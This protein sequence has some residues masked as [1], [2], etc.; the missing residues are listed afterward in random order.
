MIKKPGHEKGA[1][2]MT[3]RED[4]VKKLHAQL[5]EW[6]SEIDVLRADAHRARIE[7]EAEFE[8]RIEQLQQK[9]EA[10]KERD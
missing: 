2:I 6:H 10:A 7:T 4:Y 5:D 9:C 1:G 8:K 3:S